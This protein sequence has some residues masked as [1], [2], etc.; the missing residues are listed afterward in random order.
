MKYNLIHDTYRIIKS[1]IYI[2]SL[3]LLFMIASAST[4]QWAY[5]KDVSEFSVFL[6]TMVMNNYTYGSMIFFWIFP[7]IAGLPILCVKEKLSSSSSKNILLCLAEAFFTGGTLPFLTIIFDYCLLTTTN[8]TYM[9][10]PNDMITTYQSGMIMSELFFLKPRV[11]ILVWSLLM[12]VWGG[13]FSTFL[14]LIY[15]LTNKKII[16]MFIL[17]LLYFFNY[18]IGLKTALPSW[19][20]LFFAETPINN[21]NNYIIGYTLLIGLNM[22]LL[23]IYRRIKVSKEFVKV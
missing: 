18:V 17:L 5:K 8:T 15:S 16:S 21:I 13:L 23:V 9:P 22:I 3:L 2:F 14:I 19:H 12:F 7:L 11:F 4:I 10:I 1:R 20:D 6:K